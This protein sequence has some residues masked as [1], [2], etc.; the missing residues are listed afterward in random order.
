[1]TLPI[2]RVDL[3]GG[4]E[5]EGVEDMYIAE[6]IALICVF[7]F[8]LAGMVWDLKTRRLPNLLTVP[9]FG[10]G[11]LFHV[12]KGYFC[13][14]G[15]S[16]AFQ[17]LQFALAGFA[18]GF[19]LMLLL[20]FIGGSGGGDVKF[21]G[22]LGCWLGAWMTLQVLVL[23]SLLSGVITVS[24]MGNKVFR[25]QR[26]SVDKPDERVQ[27]VRKKKKRS[28]WTKTLRSRENWVVPFG[29]PAALGTWIVLALAWFGYKLPWPPI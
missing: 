11:L 26:L 19:C 12:V 14:A 10:L 1:M 24:I 20:W 13:E 25:L 18:L 8:T 9:A 15:L 3:W 2:L 17:G 21:I 23:S 6:L 29:V 27:K 4:E 7:A 22:A 16:G 28:G 5:R